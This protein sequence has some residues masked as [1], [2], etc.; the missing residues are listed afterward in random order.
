MQHLCKRI[1][2]CPLSGGEGSG[3]SRPG[4]RFHVEECPVTE[5][6]EEDESIKHAICES[7]Y[8]KTHWCNHN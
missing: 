8:E 5:W 7:K 6:E 4:C 2:G 1:K 3:P